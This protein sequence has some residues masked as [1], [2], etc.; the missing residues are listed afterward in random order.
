MNELGEYF[1]GLAYG[2]QLVWLPKIED[3]KELNDLSKFEGMK[4]FT[5]YEI[6]YEYI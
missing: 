4:R 2:G 1:A 5:H 6:I 3:A